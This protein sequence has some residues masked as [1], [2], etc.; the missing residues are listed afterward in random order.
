[1]AYT[2]SC[3]DRQLLDSDRGTPGS[4]I[5]KFPQYLCEPLARKGKLR[6]TAVTLPQLRPD[7]C[8]VGKHSATKLAGAARTMPHL[9]EPDRMAISAC[10]IGCGRVLGLL[11]MADL[12]S[13][14]RVGSRCIFLFKQCCACEWHRL[15]DF[16]L[17]PRG[18]GSAGC[19]KPL[20]TGPADNLWHLPWPSSGHYPSGIG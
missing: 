11:H 1:M 15:H 20:V 3:N 9:Q 8:V 5:W 4:G 19:G 10:G 18:F 13:G 6:K 14:P 2:H 12:Q 16:P 7:A 17:A